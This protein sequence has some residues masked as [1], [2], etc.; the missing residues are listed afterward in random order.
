MKKLLRTALILRCD[1]AEF[2]IYSKSDQLNQNIDDLFYLLPD[3][4]NTFFETSILSPHYNKLQQNS[5]KV[6]EPGIQQ[7]WK[8]LKQTKDI[9]I[10]S[11]FISSNNQ[12][13]LIKLKDLRGIFIIL[14]VG[15]TMAGFLLT[16]EIFC[17][18]FLRKL[19]M[20]SIFYKRYKKGKRMKTRRIQVA[21]MPVIPE[22]V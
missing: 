1:L 11:G 20:K 2:L 8:R 17:F 6:F 3:Q 10:D 18:D 13:N 9:N 15:L 19:R 7:Y 5:T 21:P 14:A 12:G 16:L 4:I 22:E